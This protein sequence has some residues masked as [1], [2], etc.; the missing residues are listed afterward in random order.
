MIRPLCPICHKKM[1]TRRVINNVCSFR[2]HTHS[3]LHLD[4][5]LNIIEYEV[6][7][8]LHKKLYWIISSSSDQKQMTRIHRVYKIRDCDT[9]IRLI[10][11]DEFFPYP[12][13]TRKLLKRLL[14]LKAFL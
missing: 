1:K 8:M 14:K 12:S 13:S 9:D 7:H 5:S 10:E 6:F 3:M 11:M 2:C 4:T